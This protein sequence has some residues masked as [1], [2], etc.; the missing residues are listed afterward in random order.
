MQ[1][2]KDDKYWQNNPQDFYSICIL[3]CTVLQEEFLLSTLS[4]F[5]IQSSVNDYMNN[6][7]EK[8]TILQIGEFKDYCGK[9]GIGAVIN[10]IQFLSQC[11]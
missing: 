2:R 6:I 3:N 1:C 9:F 5:I 7:I 11:S 8:G 10:E 4:A